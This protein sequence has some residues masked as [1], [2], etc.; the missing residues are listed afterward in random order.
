MDGGGEPVDLGATGL[1]R[2]LVRFERVMGG[3]FPQWLD[4]LALR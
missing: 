1:P 4:R 3:R 2:A